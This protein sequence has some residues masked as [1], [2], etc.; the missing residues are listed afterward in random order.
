M[1]DGELFN[2]HNF[3]LNHKFSLAPVT[4]EFLGVLLL[5]N[6]GIKTKQQLLFT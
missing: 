5:P 4:I 3:V 1:Q 6:V 2:K